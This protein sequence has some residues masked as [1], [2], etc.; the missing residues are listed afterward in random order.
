MKPVKYFLKAKGL[1]VL[2]D[3]PVIINQIFMRNPTIVCKLW[4]IDKDDY[5]LQINEQEY[6]GSEEINGE[7]THIFC[8]N[9]IQTLKEAYQEVSEQML[10][11]TLKK[12]YDRHKEVVKCNSAKARKK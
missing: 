9:K 7:P 2:T 4:A 8:N 5:A 12:R 10:V 11:I 3:S 6:T 1:F